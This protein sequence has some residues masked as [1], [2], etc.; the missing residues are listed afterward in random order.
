MFTHQNV[1]ILNFEFTRMEIQHLCI[2][3]NVR[4]HSSNKSDHLYMHE[5]ELLDYSDSKVLNTRAKNP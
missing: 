1:N 5:D 2:F 3:L 4:T